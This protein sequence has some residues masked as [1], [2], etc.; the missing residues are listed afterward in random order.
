MRVRKR[1]GSAHGTGGSDPRRPALAPGDFGRGKKIP[2]PHIPGQKPDMIGPLLESGKRALGRI[3]FYK[4]VWDLGFDLGYYG[5]LL[6]KHWRK[7]QDLEEIP[8]VQYPIQWTNP[9]NAFNFC[10]CPIPP[11]GPL[12]FVAQTNTSASGVGNNR[13]I[14]NQCIGGQ[15]VTIS[16]PTTVQGGMWEL[17]TTSPDRYRHHWSYRRRTG[18]PDPGVIP[19]YIPGRVVPLP[20]PMPMAD[21][22]LDPG[23]RPWRIPKPGPQPLPVRTVPRPGRTPAPAPSPRPQRAPRP[24]PGSPTR[25]APRAPVAPGDP[26]LKPIPDYTRPDRPPLY[27]SP[28][29]N[30]PV[31]LPGESKSPPVTPGRHVHAPASPGKNERKRKLGRG[32]RAGDLYGAATEAGDLADALASALPPS[33]QKEYRKQKGLH[34][35][36]KYL[37]RNWRHID[38]GKAAR[39]W[40]EDNAEDAAI[41]LANK[42]G[43]RITKHP[44]WRGMRGVGPTRIGG[45][46]PG[47]RF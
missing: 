47:V 21:P 10:F 2:I 43:N 12:V 9:N 31:P 41:G 18:Q 36:A 30:I 25:P 20:S 7:S 45:G 37:A 16:P 15:A 1:S 19:K 8:W 34:N 24:R 22:Y 39:A 26:D 11:T 46:L 29:T 4:K 17:R 42:A 35:K 32:G 5:A 14:V 40:A 13:C 27:T 28:A 23:I 6:Y 44:N 33:F 3:I 38:P